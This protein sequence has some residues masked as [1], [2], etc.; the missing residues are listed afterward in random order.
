MIWPIQMNKLENEAENALILCAKA[1]EL[2]V[3][4]SD[5][6]KANGCVVTNK[7]VHG[8]ADRPLSKLAKVLKK[9]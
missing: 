2:I 5:R 7:F 4:E 6:A 3:I 9:I 1:L 8:L